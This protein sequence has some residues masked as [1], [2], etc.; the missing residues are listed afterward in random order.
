MTYVALLRGINVGGNNK[1]EMPRL[2]RTFERA[3]MTA[4]ATYIN[5]GNVIFSTDGR[6]SADL[7]ATLETAIQA[8]FGLKIPVLVRSRNEIEAVYTALPAHWENGTAMK[9]DVLFLWDEIDAPDILDQLPL[10]PS[11]ATTIYVPGAVLVS[12]ARADV[13]RCGL[14]KLVGSRLYTAMTIRNVNTL[15]RIHSLMTTED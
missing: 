2:R 15:R 9:S 4:V 5:S 12:I 11:L 7:S 10:K 13:A 3:G 8:D 14:N 1:I 6:T